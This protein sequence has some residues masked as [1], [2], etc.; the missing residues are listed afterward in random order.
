MAEASPAAAAC[1]VSER[2]GEN[3]TSNERASHLLEPHAR[4]LLVHLHTK[5]IFET[6]TEFAHGVAARARLG[7]KSAHKTDTG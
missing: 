6:R 5:A 7:R 2:I 1:I 3:R 4:G